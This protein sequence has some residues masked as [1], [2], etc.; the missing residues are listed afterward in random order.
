[1][2]RA[3][4][5]ILVDDH[6]QPRHDARKALEQILDQPTIHE[7][8]DAPTAQAHYRREGA[9]LLVTDIVMPGM[10][11]IEL[12]AS[13][14]SHQT[15]PVILH[16]G[17]WARDTLYR[18]ITTGALD[19]LPLEIVNK[20]Y[21]FASFEAYAANFR[22]HLEHAQEKARRQGSLDVRPLTEL[23]KKLHQKDTLIDYLRSTYDE[24]STAFHRAVE[25][26]T[27]PALPPERRAALLREE[28]NF[29]QPSAELFL[30]NLRYPLQAWQSILRP[31]R[32]GADYGE[33]AG[34][35][36]RMERIKDIASKEIAGFAP[37]AREL[38]AYREAVEK[39]PRK[40]LPEQPVPVKARNRQITLAGTGTPFILLQPGEEPDVA[41]IEE[42]FKPT[43]AVIVRSMHP[44]EDAAVPLAGFFHSQSAYQQTDLANAIDFV[45]NIKMVPTDEFCRYRGFLPPDMRKMVVGIEPYRNVKYRGAL[46]EHPNQEGMVIVELSRTGLEHNPGHQQDFMYDTKTREVVDEIG[47]LT[48]DIARLGDV[49]AARLKENK[50]K[51]AAAGIDA[52]AYAYQMEFGLNDVDE[53]YDFQMRAFK[54]KQPA[55]PFDVKNSTYARTVF[56]VT[57]PEGEEMIVVRARTKLDELCWLAE[58]AGQQGIGVVYLTSID[59]ENQL[60]PFCMPRLDLILTGKD[61]AVQ[62]HD[63]FNA[64]V[65]A[66][67]AVLL[68]LGGSYQLQQTLA[69]GDRI[70]YVSNGVEASITK[71][72]TDDA[73]R[74]RIRDAMNHTRP[75]PNA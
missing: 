48:I 5:I 38:H 6:A 36:G 75:T 23:H 24:L 22:T 41:A 69:H 53:V 39:R 20:P 73:V 50:Q 11:G 9:D 62:S 61:F 71:I 35:L 70:R 1:M 49:L 46:L 65:H 14:L 17:S 67:H 66:R 32:D 52:H 25:S 42:V 3:M 13:V 33:V 57:E 44:S 54:K 58:F 16:T 56:G 74:Y 4:N 19:R 37:S 60:D 15:M 27:D 8:D 30:H 28:I 64:L 72:N 68:T 31:Y 51:L 34:L 18:L 29:S 7:F 43:G 63:Y 26:I 47:R 45:R 55:S 40:P 2:R 12:A 21:Y 59:K 10:S